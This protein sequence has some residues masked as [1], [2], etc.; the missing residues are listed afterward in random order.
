MTFSFIGIAGLAFAPQYWLILLS[1][2]FLGFGSA[3]FHPEGSRV[4]FMA[5][6]PK[7]GTFSIDLSSWR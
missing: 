3:V 6:G 2:I 7:E 1:V 5:A 4:S